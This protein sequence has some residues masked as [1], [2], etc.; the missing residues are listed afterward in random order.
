MAERDPAEARLWAMTVVR[1]GGIGLATTG[2]WVAASS[3]GQAL[4]L[5]SGILLIAKGA[6]V[7]LLGP[8]ALNR[9]WR[10]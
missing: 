5:G 9:W 6:G 7:T 8:K 3:A 10:R 2:M 4:A 1:L